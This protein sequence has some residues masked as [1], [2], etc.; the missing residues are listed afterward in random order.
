M[1]ALSFILGAFFFCLVL[2]TAE[3]VTHKLVELVL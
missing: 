2:W 1:F 3:K